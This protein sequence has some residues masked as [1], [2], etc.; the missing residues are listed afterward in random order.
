MVMQLQCTHQNKNSK[1]QKQT[2]L[3]KH[4][5]KALALPFSAIWQGTM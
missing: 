4:S 2:V 3:K 5:F 1:T